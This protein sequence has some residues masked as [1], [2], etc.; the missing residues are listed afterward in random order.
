VPGFTR[1]DWYS[2]AGVAVPIARPVGELVKFLLEVGATSV[3]AHLDAWGAI[4]NSCRE[5]N[6]K[7][8]SSS[9]CP[10]PGQEFEQLKDHQ[11]SFDRLPGSRTFW[12][13][14]RRSLVDYHQQNRTDRYTMP[15]TNPLLSYWPVL[16][17]FPFPYHPLL[18]GIGQS[19]H[20]VER[21]N[22]QNQPTTLMRVNSSVL[23]YFDSI[24]KFIRKEG[25]HVVIAQCRG[26]KI[27]PFATVPNFDGDGKTVLVQAPLTTSPRNLPS[28]NPSYVFP[29]SDK[30]YRES[31]TC[32]SPAEFLVLTL[33]LLAWPYEI[34]QMIVE[35]AR[36]ESRPASTVYQDDL[37]CAECIRSGRT[38]CCCDDDIVERI[39]PGDPV[40]GRLLK[41]YSGHVFCSTAD[42][43]IET[44]ACGNRS[45]PTPYF[46]SGC[47]RCG[48]NEDPES[49][50]VD[51]LDVL[52]YSIA[53]EFVQA[54]LPR[55]GD[56]NF[57]DVRNTWPHVTPMSSHEFKQRNDHL[58]ALNQK[59]AIEIEWRQS[60]PQALAQFTIDETI[61]YAP[62]DGSWRE[63]A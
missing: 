47:V 44:C 37:I 55:L 57:S 11:P 63:L 5:A 18:V 58:K 29:E 36:E 45:Y 60:C 61:P 21:R 54:K 6:V 28:Y 9:I 52:N 22:Y 8:R 39:L 25:F 33:C 13:I 34:R 17:V 16:A 62:F 53:H 32:R 42:W 14:I 56:M 46:C 2:A 7:C 35:M 4:L 48:V 12:V 3:V 27:M 19:F 59:R 41:C 10:I 1:H 40:V 30:D 24:D 15:S 38:M 49:R 31:L 23:P 20:S 43:I 50:N 51:D 26:G